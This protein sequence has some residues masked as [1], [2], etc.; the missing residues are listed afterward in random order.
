MPGEI[1]QQNETKERG[2]NALRDLARLLARHTASEAILAT[3]DAK[4]ARPSP[5]QLD[6]DNSHGTGIRKPADN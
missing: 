6:E 3:K 5:N 2:A 1:N 4:P